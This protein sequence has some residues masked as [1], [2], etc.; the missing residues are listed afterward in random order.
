MTILI[1]IYVCKLWTIFWINSNRKIQ[2]NIFSMNHHSWAPRIIE[3][4]FNINNITIIFILRIYINLNHTNRVIT[5]LFTHELSRFKIWFFCSRRMKFLEK[6]A[7]TKTATSYP[8]HLKYYYT[9]Y[10][11]SGS[12]SECLLE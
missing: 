8:D 4:N 12:V 1:I 10:S 5:I 6:I 2:N 3:E 7:L 9:D 11:I